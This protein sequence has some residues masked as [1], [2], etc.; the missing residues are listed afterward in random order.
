[1]GGG[2]K[3]TRSTAADQPAPLPDYK[4]TWLAYINIHRE[5]NISTLMHARQ[6]FC[7]KRSRSDPFARSLSE[8]FA[9]RLSDPLPWVL[10]GPPCGSK[11]NQLKV[12]GRSSPN[13]DTH[14]CPVGFPFEPTPNREMTHQT[15]TLKTDTPCQ[16]LGLKSRCLD[17]ERRERPGTGADGGAVADG[18]KVLLCSPGPGERTRPCHEW[19][20]GKATSGTVQLLISSVGFPT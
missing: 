1:M 19:T 20:H 8:P 4:E 17:N 9:R 3:H 11:A 12:M 14:G 2:D 13:R 10:R 15:G 5:A 6:A 16:V 18:V 7:K